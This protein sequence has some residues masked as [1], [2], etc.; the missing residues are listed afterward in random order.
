MRPSRVAPHHHELPK[1]IDVCSALQKCLIR[2]DSSL[3][4][5]LM[6]LDASGIQLVLVAGHDE[7][8]TGLLTD[9]DV[10]RALLKGASLD[11]RVEPYMKRNFT[12]VGPTV[13]RVEVLELMR[14]RQ[15]NEVPIVDS[16]GRLCGVHLARDVLGREVR[17]NWAVVMAGGRG[18]RLG[19]LTNSTPKPML[20]VAGRPILE[21]IVLH[22]VGAGIARIFLATNYL[23]HLIEEHFGNGENFGCRIDYLREE[24]PLGT[25][26]ALGLLPEAP[27]RGVLVMNGDLVTQA[28]VA[29]MI[30][31]H[32]AG[33]HA[34][35][36]AVRRYLHHIPFG[37]VDVDGDSISSIEEKPLIRKMINAGIY[38][39]A[40]EIVARVPRG[41]VTWMPGLVAEAV[42]AGD[43]V[44]AFEIEGDW[45][46]VGQRDEFMRA[47]GEHT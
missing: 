34:A 35:T 36:M 8:L 24:E 2:E 22:L 30:D 4:D 19:P 23:G 39:V 46:D 47:R 14:A 5:A 42:A 40:P 29:A 7:R 21:R 27:S 31:F 1:G 9:G 18:S 45:I 10:R 44:K 12:Q 20:R 28:N 13:S 15:I 26:G 33:R 16:R 37:C 43:L 41:Q 11:A 17:E 32:E 38:V 3:R 6:S 25:G